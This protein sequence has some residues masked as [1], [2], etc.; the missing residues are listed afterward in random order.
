M[1]LSTRFLVSVLALSW[2]VLA[3]CPN[4]GPDTEPLRQTAE[5]SSVT[6]LPAQLHRQ[7]SGNDRS[8]L[9]TK[10]TRREL[11]ISTYNNPGYGVSFRYPR[12]YTLE[13]G[14][15]QEHSYFLKRQE[16]LSIEQPGATLVATV[17]IPE[18]AYP[19]TT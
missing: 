8:H 11:A 10:R 14:S 6:A 4:K 16:E 7:L 9:A 3:V 12:N 19:N 18:D 5:V 13:E 2:I 17:L 1:S 15:V